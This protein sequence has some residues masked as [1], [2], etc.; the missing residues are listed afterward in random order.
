MTLF[1][2]PPIFMAHRVERLQTRFGPTSFS[3]KAAP[4]RITGTLELPS[5]YRPSAIR[6]RL[7]TE[8]PV[9]SV[10]VNGRAAPFDAATKTVTLPA[11][12]PRVEVE[13]ILAG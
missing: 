5:R 1:A 4:G 10:R 12:G 9:V 2:L 3:L 6:L 7:R 11:G 8:K 13:A